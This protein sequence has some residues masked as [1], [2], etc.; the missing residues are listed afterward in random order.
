MFSCGYTLIGNKMKNAI[1]QFFLNYNG[2]GKESGHYS[3]DGIPEWAQY[4]NA[5]FKRYAE[6][7]DADYFFFQD[8]F[9]NSRSN[10]F[11]VLRLYKDEIFDLYDK[12]LYVDADIM[13]KNLEANIFELDVKDVAGW[14]EWRHPEHVLPVNW[15]AT[16]P[17]VNRFQQFGAPVIKPESVQGSI[18]MINSGVMLWS[19]EARLK[20]REKFFDHEEWFNYRNAWLDKKWVNI[21]GHSTHCLDQPFLNANFNRFNFDVMELS[22]VWNR[23]PTK[24]EDYPC[25]FAHYVGKSRYNIPKIFEDIR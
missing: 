19:R 1:F 18:R 15:S 3:E 7:H 10:F 22:N 4:S 6:K 2:V 12:V 11:E 24:S 21:G 20:A 25:N 5:Y 23:F 14:P 13:P 8:R 17:L 16:G 9:V